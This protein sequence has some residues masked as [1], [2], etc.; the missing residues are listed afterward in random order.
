MLRHP[1]EDGAALAEDGGLGGAVLAQAGLVDL[2]AQ[3]VGHGLEAVADAEDRDSGLKEVGADGG[4]PV[5]VNA[6]GATGKNDGGGVLGQELLGGEGMRNHFR[7]HI[8]FPDAAGNQLRVLGTV[9]NNQHRLLGSLGCSGSSHRTSLLCGVALP[10]LQDRG[11][12]AVNVRRRDSPTAAAF[13][14]AVRPAGSRQVRL[15][16]RRATSSPPRRTGTAPRR[17]G[18]GG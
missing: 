13:S 7:I 3:G 14:T 8:R 5:R 4:R 9:V 2:S 12:D 18:P 10:H 6:G 1:L 11:C 16:P 15:P 17:R